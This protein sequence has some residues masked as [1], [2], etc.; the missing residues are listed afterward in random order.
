MKEI[1]KPIPKF[2]EYEASTLGRVRSRK[3]SKAWKI[4]RITCDRKGY[5][6]LTLGR[7]LSVNSVTIRVHRVVLM[8]F[9]RDRSAG[10]QCRHLDGNPSNNRLSNLAWGTPKENAN[11]KIAHGTVLSGEYHPRAK[12]KQG[13]II[14]IRMLRGAGYTYR[15][16]ASMFGVNSGTICHAVSGRNWG[17]NRMP[18]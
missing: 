17:K 2:S 14:K 16:I 5:G 8:T 6:W 12:L 18:I 13:D 11:D 9:H 10:E 15:A 4:M 1:W 3:R 7:G